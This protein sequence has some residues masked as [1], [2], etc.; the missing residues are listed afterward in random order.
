MGKTLWDAYLERVN[1]RT[2]DGFLLDGRGL[3]RLDAEAMQYRA[4]YLR[5]RRACV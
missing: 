4:A 3:L 2:A 1:G 5:N